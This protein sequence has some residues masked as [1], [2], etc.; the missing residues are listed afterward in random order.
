MSAVN[1]EYS[2]YDVVFVDDA[3]TDDTGAIAGRLMEKWDST[4]GEFELV[5]NS[6][7]LKALENLYN[8]VHS[9]KPGTIIVALDGDDWLQNKHVLEY[10][11]QIYLD[12]TTWI[13]AGS[14]IESIGGRVVRP[15]ISKDYWEGNIRHKDWTFSHLRTFKKELFTKISKADM[16]DKDGEFVDYQN[17]IDGHMLNDYQ[18][19]TTKYTFG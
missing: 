18:H 10:M 3:S 15:R 8:V 4:K 16:I 7:N 11:S 19:L 1:Q 12:S 2:N 6:R 17:Q 9:S 5:H 13:T 14:Y